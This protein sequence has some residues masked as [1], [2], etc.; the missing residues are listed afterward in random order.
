MTILLKLPSIIWN[1]IQRLFFFSISLSIL[2]FH[3]CKNAPHEDPVVIEKDIIKEQTVNVLVFLKSSLLELYFNKNKSEVYTIQNSNLPLGK[4]DIVNIKN[5]RLY[6]NLPN[7]YD[8]RKALAD[9]RIFQ[10][11]A[12]NFV[13]LE[14]ID[15][16]KYL[17]INKINIEQIVFF[18]NDTRKGGNFEPCYP[19]PHWMSELYAQLELELASFIHQENQ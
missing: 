16:E 3:A 19:C 1:K 17:K 4:Y 10:E 11:Q 14:D 15:F 8:Q 6:F 2:F 13:A 7:R 12:D 18:P 5:N 9:K